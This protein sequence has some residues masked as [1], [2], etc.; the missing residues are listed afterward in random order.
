VDRRAWRWRQRFDR[1]FRADLPDRVAA[2]PNN[3]FLKLAAI[4]GQSEQFPQNER[5]RP[6]LHPVIAICRNWF[7][8]IA[9]QAI[10][11]TIMHTVSRR[12]LLAVTAGSSLANDKPA[13][14][15]Q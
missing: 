15:P 4:V 13:V 12:N 14:T 7:S 1:G 2:C 11:E 6:S 10:G 3:S 5:G 9:R 8:F